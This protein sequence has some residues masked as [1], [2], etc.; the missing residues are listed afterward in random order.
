MEETKIYLN[1]IGF[2]PMID[3]VRACD[4]YIE[5]YG[6]PVTDDLLKSLKSHIEKD[7]ETDLANDDFSYEVICERAEEFMLWR[8]Y[9]DSQIQQVLKVIDIKVD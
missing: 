2:T 5:V 4:W 9:D 6:E 7:I 3:N 1:F 8:G